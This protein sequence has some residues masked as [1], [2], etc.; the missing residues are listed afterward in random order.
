MKSFPGSV[1]E[2]LIIQD[3]QEVLKVLPSSNLVKGSIQRLG[4]KWRD[5][6]LLLTYI[7]TL[8]SINQSTF[9]AFFIKEEEKGSVYVGEEVNF[10]G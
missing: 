4:A 9:L 6:N 3:M 2:F 1:G 8:Q 5:Q 10:A 7:P